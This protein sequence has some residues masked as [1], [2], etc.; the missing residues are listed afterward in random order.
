MLGGSARRRRQLNQSGAVTAVTA[1]DEAAVPVERRSA[2][3]VSATT[4]KWCVKTRNA[5]SRVK[6]NG[7]SQTL[8]A[9]CSVVH[10][11]RLS[12]ARWR[13]HQRTG[14]QQP[15]DFRRAVARPRSPDIRRR[16]VPA[17][18]LPPRNTEEEWRARGASKVRMGTPAKTNGA[19]L[20]GM[21]KVPASKAVCSDGLG[22]IARRGAH[23]AHN[24]RPLN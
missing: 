10:M 17:V 11:S 2:S 19:L 23:R 12:Q 3:K 5:P 15:S 14:Q 7:N 13:R 6:G 4:P 9:K 16:W 18:R 22:G 1:T 24:L 21:L 8:P 20:H